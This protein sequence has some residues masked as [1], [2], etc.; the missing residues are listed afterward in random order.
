[1]SHSTTKPERRGPDGLTKT[2]R[3]LLRDPNRYLVTRTGEGWTVTHLDVPVEFTATRVPGSRDS[4]WVFSGT[5][6]LTYRSSADRCS[7]PD[8]DRAVEQGRPCKHRA[9]VISI[10][11]HQAQRRLA[12]RVEQQVEEAYPAPEVVGSTVYLVRA[13]VF[14]PD[15]YA[16]ALAA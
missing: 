8:H 15:V 7:C 10:L 9:V 13:L 5:S 1:M 2:E 16:V 3:G 4:L 14:N 6:G 11:L 12:A